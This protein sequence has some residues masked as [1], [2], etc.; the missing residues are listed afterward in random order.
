M[1]KAAPVGRRIKS[2]QSTLIYL[3]VPRLSASEATFT[4]P[5][6]AQIAAITA[7]ILKIFFI[8]TILYK[9]ISVNA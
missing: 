5:K 3:C 7:K 4:I 2:D 9:K 6:I 8:P 1:K